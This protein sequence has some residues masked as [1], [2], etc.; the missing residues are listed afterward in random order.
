MSS[1]ANK[2]SSPPPILRT[3]VVHRPLAEGFTVFTDEIGS[4]WPLPTHSVFRESAG[5]V[6]FVDG[7][8]VER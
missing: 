5:G 2:T 4:W 6:H 1:G 3:A 8:L 7:R